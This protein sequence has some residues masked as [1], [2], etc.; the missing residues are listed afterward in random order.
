MSC[1]V[2][3][4]VPRTP[5][6]TPFPCFNFFYCLS[7]DFS[8][9]ISLIRFTGPF[10]Y[11]PPHVLFSLP[12]T[13]VPQIRKQGRKKISNSICREKKG[14]NRVPK[15]PLLLSVFFSA[16]ASFNWPRMIVEVEKGA[17]IRV[18]QINSK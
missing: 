10:Y 16:L 9:E 12:R 8:D 7:R 18:R 3:S 5:R 13:I 14:A 1:S 11:K 2:R 17:G 4:F 15:S 6:N